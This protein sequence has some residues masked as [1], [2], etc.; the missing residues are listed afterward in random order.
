VEN[1]LIKKFFQEDLSE[2]EE[3][4]LG[5]QLLSS[6]EDALRFGEEAH[7]RYASYGLPEPEWSKP[8]VPALGQAAAS[9]ATLHFAYI[10]LKVLAGLLALAVAGVVAFGLWRAFAPVPM[11]SGSPA[12]ALQ[13]SQAPLL[14]PSQIHK[15]HFPSPVKAPLVVPVL[16][17]IDMDHP[18]DKP[19][20]NLSIT[21]HKVSAGAVTVEVTDLEGQGLLPLYRGF[22]QPGN[23]G[24]EWNGK[25]GNGQAASP[26]YYQI[27]MDSGSVSQK[28]VIQ[29][30]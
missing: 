15:V 26:G 11:D 5:E 1:D 18:S 24:F 10:G 28:K 14:A 13:D 6:T 29:I 20:S 19:F 25:L 8:L 2:A 16:T 23:W 21:V 22:L 4:A 9:P 17:P 30:Q 7:T 12:P 3:K 27:Q